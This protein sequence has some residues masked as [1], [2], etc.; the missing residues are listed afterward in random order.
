MRR[1]QIPP[2]LLVGD[3][4]VE[5]NRFGMADMEI[6]VRFRWKAG[7]DP[8]AMFAGGAIGRDDLTDEVRA[9]RRFWRGGH[10]GR[11]SVEHADDETRMVLSQNGGVG[12]E[13][14]VCR[15]CRVDFFWIDRTDYFRI[16][17]L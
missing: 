4:E 1:W 7:D 13:G 15:P 17:R 2:E 14:P 11:C 12:E 9:C 5:T 16:K 6:A 8:T 3:A 10:G